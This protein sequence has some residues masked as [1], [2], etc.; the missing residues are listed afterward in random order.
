MEG[1]TWVKCEN[2]VYFAGADEEVSYQH[3]YE[4][5]RDAQGDVYPWADY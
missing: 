2:G 1:D 3:V 5:L 4:L